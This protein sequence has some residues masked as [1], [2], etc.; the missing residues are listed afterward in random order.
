MPPS[1]QGASAAQ[2]VGIM[3]N[4]DRDHEERAAAIARLIE[5]R[6]AASFAAYWLIVTMPRWYELID[7]AMT[8]GAGSSVKWD[9]QN[10]QAARARQTAD[11]LHL[12]ASA[13]NLSS[14]IRHQAACALVE[15]SGAEGY[16]RVKGQLS[17]TGWRWIGM[18]MAE[19]QCAYYSAQFLIADRA[20]PMAIRVSLA[21]DCIDDRATR[22]DLPRAV[23]EFMASPKT[24][25]MHRLALALRLT[26]A[27]ERNGNARGQQGLRRLSADGTM[28]GL[29]RVRAAEA[30][31]AV[32]PEAGADALTEIADAA[33]LDA[34]TRELA[35]RSADQQL[36]G[37][38]V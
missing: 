23:E 30:L 6:G 37:R 20:V 4:A 29:D 33:D 11:G 32:D 25:S 5:A 1:Q 16:A 19:E 24:P 35:R 3:M 18:M 13:R 12:L 34:S 2:L 27:G 38:S 31:M 8:Y 17:R 9:D 26:E 21:E 28:A 14:D 7:I 15:H 10:D 36:K 22:A